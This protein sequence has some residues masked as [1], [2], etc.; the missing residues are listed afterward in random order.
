M[1][2][3]FMMSVNATPCHVRRAEA[4]CAKRPGA[5]KVEALAKTAYAET[6]KT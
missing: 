5:M 6:E 3:Y 2:P 4:L 1:L